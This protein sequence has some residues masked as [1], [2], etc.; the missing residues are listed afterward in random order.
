MK[1]KLIA[2]LFLAKCLCY[3]ASRI[4]RGYK[5]NMLILDLEQP[6]GRRRIQYRITDEKYVL[7]D[8]DFGRPFG[9]LD[10]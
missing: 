5:W 2:L 6:E 10:A 3:I 1:H 7:E 4:L 8:F 9:D